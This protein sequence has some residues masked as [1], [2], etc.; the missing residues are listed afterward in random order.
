MLRLLW[1]N[2]SVLYS[3]IAGG[4][5]VNAS[6]GAFRWFYVFLAIHGGLWALYR[7]IDLALSESRE[8]SL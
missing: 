3:A 5:A 4:L 8:R 7:A 6:P 2:I 1:F